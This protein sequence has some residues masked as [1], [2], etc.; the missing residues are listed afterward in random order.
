MAKFATLKAE[1]GQKLIFEGK[2]TT[3]AIVIPNERTSFKRFGEVHMSLK[4]EDAS[5][6]G[7][8]RHFG[9]ANE[10]SDKVAKSSRIIRVQ[11]I[12]GEVMNLDPEGGMP[13]NQVLQRSS[14]HPL[15]ENDEMTFNTPRTSF[16]NLVCSYSGK[17]GDNK[18]ITI[19]VGELNLGA[20]IPNI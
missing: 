2:P 13:E 3:G 16:K 4:T 12:A 18:F 10:I 5:H 20:E 1:I 9:G 8:I 15:L 7:T 6:R 19:Q 11:S 17:K 14:R